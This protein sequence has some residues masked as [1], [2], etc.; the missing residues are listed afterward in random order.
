MTETVANVIKLEPEVFEREYEVL[1][2]RK[3]GL[4][5]DQI[6]QKL[7]YAQ[8]SGA[9]AAFKRA[10]ERTRDDALATEGRALHRA[11]LETALNAIWPKVLKGDLRAI[12][13][14]LKILERDAKLYG[15]DSPVKTELEVT[16]YDGNLLRQRTREI[17]QTI[18]EVRGQT[19]SVGDGSSEAGTVTK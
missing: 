15:L 13:R 19:D 12:D 5:F 18:R 6:A 7:G 1:K 14:M 4:T 3:G 17:I 16:T 9:R 8:E 11:R 10:I 2:Y